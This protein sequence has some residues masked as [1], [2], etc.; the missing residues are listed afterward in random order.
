LDFPSILLGDSVDGDTDGLTDKEEADVFNTDPG[1]PDTDN[2]GYQDGHEAYYLYNPAGKEPERLI[3]AGFFKEY[4]NP[5]WHYK[6]YYPSMWALGNIDNE[7]RDILWSTLTG[8][9]IELQT[10]T[11]DP[12]QSFSD[13]FSEWAPG[14]KY[15]DLVKF[16][17]YFNVQGYNRPD[18]LVYY[19][20]TT[21]RVYVLVYHNTPD[22]TVINYRTVLK[23][24][25]RSFRLPPGSA[26]S[27][28]S[29]FSSSSEKGVN[30]AA[31]STISSPVTSTLV[32]PSPVSSSTSALVTSSSTIVSSTI[33]GDTKSTSSRK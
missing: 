2:D 9:N 8:E 23:T 22:T 15:G 10:I 26:G 30:T 33:R 17:T 20:P 29:D 24:M 19:F 12:Q 4:E 11:K 32:N 3:E 28:I 18:Y 1:V 7:Y 6:I 14:E 31:S 27:I 13:W 16:E 21:D 5:Q 25:A